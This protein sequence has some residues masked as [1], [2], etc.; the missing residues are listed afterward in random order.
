MVGELHATEYRY[1][2][3]KDLSEQFRDL[4]PLD[5]QEGLTVEFLLEL[6]R[7]RHKVSTRRH[8]YLQNK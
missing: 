2:V 1:A 7:Y 3:S 8:E 5:G 4:S 6:A